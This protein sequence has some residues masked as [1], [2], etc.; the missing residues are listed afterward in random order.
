MTKED[1]KTGQS[2]DLVKT[3][4]LSPA[5]T[6]SIL[7]ISR[8]GKELSLLDVGSG[9]GS[10]FTDVVNGLV[11]KGHTLEN[12][13]VLE[14]DTKIFPH[15]LNATVAGLPSTQTQ[16]VETRKRDVIR[17][18]LGV[19]GE[20]YD[21]AILQLVLQQ[22]LNNSEAAYLMYYVYRSLKTTG[23]LLLVD[24][25]PKYI[26]YLIENE[27]A[28]FE[29]TQRGDRQST[30]WYHFDSGGRVEM[31]SR[32]IEVQLAMLLGIGLDLV[33]ITP[34]TTEAI[35]DYKER[36]DRLAKAGIPMFYLMQLRKNPEN[37][38]S[39]TEGLVLSIKPQDGGWV[40]VS[41]ADKE[42]I[43]IPRFNEWEKV[44]PGSNLIL[45]ETRRRENGLQMI[46]YWVIDRDEKI[47]GGELV[48][49]VF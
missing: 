17:E 25:H 2:V 45:H 40:L 15:L 33:K 6:K 38:V 1:G 19:N 5:L 43:L 7:G 44:K 36:Y 12:L 16:F 24:L 18:F 23:E 49:R 28:K 39:S 4:L 32:E 29:L 21:I 48:A 8:L 42:E 41:F 11:K 3:T 30:G 31:C 27:P 9:D 14:S 34:I 46:N 20:K 22:T 26:Q 13:A 37:F 47:R 35:A 10:A